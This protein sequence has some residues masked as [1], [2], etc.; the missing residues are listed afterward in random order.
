MALLPGKG[1]EGAG[2]ELTFHRVV[3]FPEQTLRLSVAG[4]TRAARAG[5]RTR[6]G[7]LSLRRMGVGDERPGGADVTSEGGV[8]AVSVRG[9]AAWGLLLCCCA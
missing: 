7:R 4:G 9:A 3:P 2:A 6:C 8:R 5:W 1:R